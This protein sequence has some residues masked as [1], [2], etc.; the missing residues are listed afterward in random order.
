M[1]HY[2]S[3]GDI[4]TAFICAASSVYRLKFCPFRGRMVNK[5]IRAVRGG[6]T[7][8][9]NYDNTPKENDGLNQP[10]DGTNTSGQANSDAA[11]QYTGI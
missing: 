10:V 4:T 8:D 2:T 9:N 6:C 11:G 1:R 5:V 7:M 3:S